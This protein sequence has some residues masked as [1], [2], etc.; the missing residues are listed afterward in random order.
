M[1]SADF[2]CDECGT[3]VVQSWRLS[4]YSAEWDADLPWESRCSEF[5]GYYPDC[6][7][8]LR[9]VWHGVAPAI[10]TSGGASRS[11]GGLG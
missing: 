4:D 10:R 8:V 7:G 3:S 5:S 9:R 2:E 6:T 1:P 11:R